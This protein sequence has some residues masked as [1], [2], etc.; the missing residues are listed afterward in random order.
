[1]YPVLFKIGPFSVYGYGLMLA[2]GFIIGSYLATIEFRRR[3]LDPNYASNITLIALVAGIIGSKIHYLIENFSLFIAD[4]IDMTFSP[5]GLTFFGGFLLAV[6]AIYYYG[7]VKKLRFLEVADALSPSVMIAYGIARVG[8]HL[9]GDG[10]YGFPTTLPWGVDYSKGTFPPSLILKDFCHIA[11]QYPNGIP[12]NIPLHPTP[13]YEFLICGVFFFVLWR[14]R[15]TLAPNGK[16]FTMYLMLAG[17]ERFS[18]EFLRLNTR[19]FLGLT[20][21]QIISLI[22]IV[23][24]VWSWHRFS[25]G[26]NTT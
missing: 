23:A 1:M 2:L 6:V 7:K 25:K 15:K 10:D 3:G 17:I 8:C 11:Q 26:V 9:A 16:L 19:I 18:I 12:D 13:I 4:P 24:G 22:I 5:G 14:F 20:Q 21:A